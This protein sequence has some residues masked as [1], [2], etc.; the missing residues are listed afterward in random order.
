MANRH[1]GHRSLAAPGVGA[2]EASRIVLSVL[3]Q[4]ADLAVHEVAPGRITIARARRPAWA[5][6]LCVAT[7]W[8]AGLGLLFLLVRRTQSGE[9]LVT[10]GPRGCLLVL[11]PLVDMATMRSLENALRSTSAFPAI[12][13]ADLLVD[14]SDS[15]DELADGLDGRTVARIDRPSDPALAPIVAPS[16]VATQPS[17]VELRFAD[18]VVVVEAGRPVVLGRDPSP[19][20]AAEGRVVPGDAATVSKSHLLVA[21][22]GTTVTVEDLGSTNGSWVHRAGVA[23]PLLPGAP[24]PV[25]D[26]DQVVIGS[27]TFVVEH[28]AGR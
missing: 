22:D 16:A 15:A 19:R 21:F 28:R 12:A 20:G 10:D 27:V 13:G 18:G 11:P 5:V 2:E 25:G 8:L 9:L 1:T 24:A 26:G 14:R 17:G 6:A 7:I 4:Q 23:E 3:G